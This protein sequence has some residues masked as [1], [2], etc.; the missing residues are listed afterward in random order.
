MGRILFKKNK[1]GVLIP[2]HH[3]NIRRRTMKKQTPAGIH[4]S[5]TILSL[6]LLALSMAVSS[7]WAGNTYKW[8]IS[9]GI[10]EDHPDLADRCLQ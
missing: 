8:K 3:P 5:F 9:Q 4:R 2:M 6:L 7:A 10:A 1:A